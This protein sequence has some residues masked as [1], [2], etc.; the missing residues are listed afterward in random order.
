MKY[1]VLLPLI[2]MMLAFVVPAFAGR[3]HF[4][5]GLK[6]GYMIPE[7]EDWKDHYGEEGF[8]TGG[9]EI[10]WKFF[11][12]LELN[13]SVGYGED[14][15]T[16]TTVTG[17]ESIDSVTFRY[18]PVHVS[19]LYRLILSE[20]QIVVPYVGGGYSHF[21]YWV[22]VNDDTISGDRMGYHARGGIQIL[23]DRFDREAAQV[24]Q[25]SEGIDNTYLFFEGIYAVGDD[26]GDEDIDLGGWQI[27]GGV[28]F[29]F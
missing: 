22:E 18:M 15:G 17:R 8:V 2:A 10:G 25:A 29:E 27:M 12:A 7:V 14:E 20:D 24:L 4:T 21:F 23:L 9:V 16:G 3:P 13:T 28:L 5:V 6:G 26:F 1:R 19:L 11:R